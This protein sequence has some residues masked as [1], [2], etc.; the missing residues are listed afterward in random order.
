MGHPKV[1]AA[2]SYEPR[3]VMDRLL[4]PS[5]PD[6]RCCE[7]KPSPTARAR[8]HWRSSGIWRVNT[9]RC[10]RDSSSK[11]GA[12]ISEWWQTSGTWVSLI[13]NHS[14]FW[15][16]QRGRECDWLIARPMWRSG[17][18]RK[19][20]HTMRQALISGSA[21][22]RHLCSAPSAEKQTTYILGERP[23]KSL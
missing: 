4:L 18:V 16:G 5:V 17:S 21:N 2:S 8:L 13:E 9:S 10:W 6:Q 22:H 11:P 20:K 1:Q 15:F 23:A 3:W 12:S 7:F 14:V 19:R